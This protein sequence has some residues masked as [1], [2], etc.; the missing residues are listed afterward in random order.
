MTKAVS[1]KSVKADQV[2]L[3]EKYEEVRLIFYDAQADL[4]AAKDELCTFNNKY[5]RVIAMMEYDQK[6]D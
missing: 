5:G 2:V 3:Q 4:K 1:V 6:E